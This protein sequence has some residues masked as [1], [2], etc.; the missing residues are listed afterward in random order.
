[1][2]SV[3]PPNPLPPDESLGGT[4]LV[5]TCILTSFTLVTTVL[6]IWARRKRHTLGWVHPPLF[7]SHL[8]DLTNTPPGRLRH[9]GLYAPRT[10][11]HK[12]PNPLCQTRQWTPSLVPFAGRLRIRQFPD[13]DDTN[14]SLHEYWVVEMQYMSAY[15]AY[16]Q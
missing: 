7:T 10:Y 12:S 6:R 2:A 5:L 16:Q 13:V 14:L 15:T 8:P 9:H 3:Q 1:M 4:L 11:T